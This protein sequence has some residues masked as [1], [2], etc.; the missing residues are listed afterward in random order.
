[1]VP[2]AE[3]LVEE[4]QFGEDYCKIIFTDALLFNHKDVVKTI[5]DPTF[6][7]SVSGKTSLKSFVVTTGGYDM[8]GGFQYSLSYALGYSDVKRIM[9]SGDV[10]PSLKLGFDEFMSELDFILSTPKRKYSLMFHE[11]Y[12]EIR[13]KPSKSI[14][15]MC[16]GKLKKNLASSSKVFLQSAKTKFQCGMI[17]YLGERYRAVPHNIYYALFD[18]LKCFSIWSG[19]SSE[20]DHDKKA[21]ER[22]NKILNQISSG[23]HR[24]F[25]KS[26]IW[27]EHKDILQAVDVRR[28]S[29]LAT[30]LY[31]MRTKA[32]YNIDFEIGEFLP[33]LSNLMLK[34]EELFT[35]GIY[36]EEGSIMTTNEQLVPIFQ[37]SREL[38]PLVNVTIK[39]SLGLH[40]LEKGKDYYYNVLQKG[41]ILA[42]DYNLK[43]VL[44]ELI[45]RKEIFISPFRPPFSRKM[46]Y[47][48][49]QKEGD[50]W[51]FYSTFG[52][53]IAREDNYLSYTIK[54]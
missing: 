21:Q 52:E 10:Y 40:M 39:D 22:L 33:E 27:R 34:V 6:G 9:H 8:Y 4:M 50:T 31:A 54:T 48:K 26:S 42:K 12:L 11:N 7:N 19:M 53:E 47:V 23:E 29:N 32:D 25:F 1:L 35:L 17:D 18:L 30:D 41:L 36:M 2:V 43:M 45:Q 28:Y 14:V 3:Y 46:Q 49:I 20:I 16:I 13:P 5:L 15:G 44:T 37:A 38:E 24:Q 51:K